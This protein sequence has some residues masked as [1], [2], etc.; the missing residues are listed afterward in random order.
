MSIV[1]PYR[2]G[3]DKEVL[4]QFPSPKILYK[5]REINDRSRDI[6]KSKQLYFPPPIFNDPFDCD[7]PVRFDLMNDDELDAMSIGILMKYKDMT[8][9]QAKEHYLSSVKSKKTWNQTTERT[10]M[11]SW[12]LN[13]LKTKA[14]IFCVTP[15]NDNILMWSHYAKCHEGICIG[16][17]MNHLYYNTGAS[18]GKVNYL[19]DYPTFKPSEKDE[20]LYIG[21]LLSKAKNWEYEEEF[22]FINLSGKNVFDIDPMAIEQII[23]GCCA[24][25]DE[26]D[27]VVSIV[28]ADK[29]LLHVNLLLAE[30]VPYQFKLSIKALKI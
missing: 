14:T 26:I 15:K 10:R 25:K 16:F 30:K 7:I 24:K 9:D 5:F 21:Q 17:N 1:Q 20:A 4:I 28:K 18:I 12:Q 6:F 8:E 2:E 11:V 13:N 29:D 23:F 27:T 3:V 22:R 19:N